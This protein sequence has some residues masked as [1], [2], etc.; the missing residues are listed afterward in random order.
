MKISFNG[1]CKE[2]TGSC[3][4]IETGSIKFLVD[5]GMF[6]GKSYYKN[7]E[8]FPFDPEV[9]DFVLLTHA[10]LDHCG[11]LP[12]IFMEG[13][14]GRI[15]STLPTRDLAEI[16]LL[17][18]LNVSRIEN[19]PFVHPLCQE[20]DIKQLMRFFTCL[21]YGNKRKINDNI[22]IRLR[23]AGHIL[24]SAIFEVWIKEDGITK[25]LVFSGDLG[26]MS[27]PI[28]KD[29][30]FIDSADLLFIESTYGNRLHES[31]K[32]GED[33]LIQEVKDTINKNGVLMIPVFS[34]ERTQ[35][36]LYRLNSF[37]EEQKINGVNIF[38][39]SP[40]AIK[41]TNIYKQYVDFFDKEAKELIFKGDDIFDFKGF[42]MVKG[43]TDEVL[44]A[45]MPKI[46]LAGSGMFEGGKIGIYL[47]KYLSNPLATLLIVSFQVDG[48]L[49]RKVISGERKIKVDNKEVEINAKISTIFSFSSHSDHRMLFDWAV[50]ANPKKIFVVHGEE[51]ASQ[52][53]AE[54]I[55][56][57]VPDYNTFYNF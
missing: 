31:K 2:V 16:I 1:A 49:G 46:I 55:N 30:E 53:L 20:S 51:P 32:M 4:L 40:L 47:K 52:F 24:G 10:H 15:Y 45:S 57:V 48:S 12:K 37:F 9:I 25:K 41:A 17:D 8:D 54:S 39:D 43:E 44:N 7:I 35:E 21:D 19:K 56:G 50:K 38:L 5:C 3:I 42:K 13:F 18:A 29:H 23:D 28:V 22:E 26:N 27:N 33:I 6:Q 34:L 14:R 36:M 11:R